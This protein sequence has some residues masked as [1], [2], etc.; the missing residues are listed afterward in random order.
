MTICMVVYSVFRFDPTARRER[1]EDTAT[2]KNKIKI[3]EEQRGNKW[4]QSVLPLALLT[5]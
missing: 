5:R 3:K 4:G 2:Q 1:Y